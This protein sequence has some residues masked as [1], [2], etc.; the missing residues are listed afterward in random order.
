MIVLFIFKTFILFLMALNIMLLTVILD[1]TNDAVRVVDESNR[2]NKTF[3]RFKKATN[4]R[5]RNR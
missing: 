2:N 3:Q 4:D 1:E 5:W